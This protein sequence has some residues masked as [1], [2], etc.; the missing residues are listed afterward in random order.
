MQHRKPAE[1][2]QIRIIWLFTTFLIGIKFT[3]EGLTA[4]GGG[5]L[6]PRSS[7]HIVNMLNTNCPP[8]PLASAA[9]ASADW[10]APRP[11]ADRD[12][13]GKHCL[14]N[15]ALL[16]PSCRTVLYHDY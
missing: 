1:Y 12:K 9:A 4:A 6:F 13:I 5:R 2:R 15:C 8:K 11:P 14:G 7:D 3:T 10:A 16:E